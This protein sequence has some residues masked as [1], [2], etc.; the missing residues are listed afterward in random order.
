[1]P[2][3]VGFY[4]TPLK[5]L[6]KS[7]LYLRIFYNRIYRER[8]GQF[9]WSKAGFVTFMDR[10]LTIKMVGLVCIRTDD[11]DFAIDMKICFSN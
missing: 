10:A 9:I 3:P 4:V 7:Y 1:M 2:Q 8:Y 6:K 5:I 11:D